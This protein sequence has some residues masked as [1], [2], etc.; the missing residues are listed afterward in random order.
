MVEQY[1]QLSLRFEKIK[2]K[3]E[4]M[5]DDNKSKIQG[6]MINTL[7]S[8]FADFEKAVKEND[9]NRITE[10]LFLIKVFLQALKL[11]VN[12]KVRDK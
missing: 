9:S 3:Y 12:K 4:E 5:P 7:E 2:K 11:S 10:L 1:N 8:G 6:D